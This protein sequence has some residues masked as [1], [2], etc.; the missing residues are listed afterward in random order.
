MS[1]EVSKNEVSKNEVTQQEKYINNITLE[2]LLNPSL[3][4]KV[5]K[6]KSGPIDEQLYQDAIFYRKR[7]CQLTKEMCKGEYINNNFKNIFLAYANNIIYGLKQIDTEDIYQK[8]YIDLN[9]CIKQGEVLQDLYDISAANNLLANIR[10]LTSNLDGFV[11]KLTVNLQD[12]VLPQK[13][14]AN[15]K[16]PALKIKGLKKKQLS[17]VKS[18][19][20]KSV[21]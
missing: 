9:G 18:S 19:Q 13:R 8:E 12:K 2:Y 5:N 14:L 20:D 1:N 17:Q 7:I 15:I 3:Y 10:P 16:D 4:E 21:K 11:K 6:K